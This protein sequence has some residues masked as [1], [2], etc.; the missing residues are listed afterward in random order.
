MTPYIVALIVLV[1]VIILLAQQWD[2][3]RHPENWR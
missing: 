2:V 3:K 1:D